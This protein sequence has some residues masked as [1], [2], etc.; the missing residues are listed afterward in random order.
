MTTDLSPEVA[1]TAHA[2]ETASSVD[3]ATTGQSDLQAPA[4]H[5]HR[6]IRRARRKAARHISSEEASDSEGDSWTRWEG[7]R[8]SKLIYQHDTERE[9]SL[10]AACGMQWSLNTN[11]LQLQAS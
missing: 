8:Y 5:Q 1:Q 7:L 6:H 11:Y 9:A 2:A 10:T 3:T 4:A